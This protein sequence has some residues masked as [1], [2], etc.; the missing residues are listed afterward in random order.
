MK[1]IRK[2]CAE[3]ARE[4]EGLAVVIDVFRA[5]TCEPLFFHFG[6]KRVVLEADPDKALELKRENP[7]FI[8]AGEVNE[9]PLEG[10]INAVRSRK[11]QRLPVVMSKEES[12]RALT[13]MSGA[14][15]LMAKLLYG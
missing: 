2:S 9:V 10:R 13:A 11:K 3:G 1:I 15:Q 7:E 8:L 14:T 12:Q 6:A 5:F 4:A